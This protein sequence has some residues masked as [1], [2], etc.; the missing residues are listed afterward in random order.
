MSK[1]TIEISYK[2]DEDTDK[3]GD[4]AV[5]GLARVDVVD[6]KAG[7]QAILASRILADAH[8]TI[9]AQQ[10]D[11]DK[12]ANLLLAAEKITSRF[13]QGIASGPDTPDPDGDHFVR[14]DEDTPEV[15]AIHPV[16]A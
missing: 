6:I 7:N 10:L 16:E 4:G 5:I 9:V 2:P 12:E 13:L 3:Y 14:P 1:I 15:V 11:A 8:K